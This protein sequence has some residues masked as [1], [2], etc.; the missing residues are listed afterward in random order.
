MKYFKATLMALL[1]AAVG[2]PGAALAAKAHF[3]WTPSTSVRGTPIYECVAYNKFGE[4]MY[5]VEFSNCPGKTKYKWVVV[6]SVSGRPIHIC[7]S[8]NAMGTELVDVSME[9]CP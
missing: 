9:Y 2:T 7:R 8:Y 1:I 3:K 6:Q 5:S 4:P